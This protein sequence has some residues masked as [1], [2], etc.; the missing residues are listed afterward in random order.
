MARKSKGKKRY[1]R[2]EKPM[3]K[4]AP[5]VSGLLAADAGTKLFF[6]TNLKEFL[7]GGLG[8]QP[9]PQAGGT[10]GQ[11]ITLPELF[12]YVTTNQG[13][14]YGIHP[15]DTRNLGDMIMTNI[16][17]NFLSSAMQFGV[18]AALPKIMT[19]TGI[20]RNTNKLLKGFGLSGV[21]QL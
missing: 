18:S 9:N 12:G 1:R 3:I 7:I 4:V 16:Q 2:R 20:T 11:A 10:F 8:Q 19:K 15:Q 6:G 5:M 21:V 14:Q 13:G 17:Q